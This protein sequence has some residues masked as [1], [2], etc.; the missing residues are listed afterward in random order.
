MAGLRSLRNLAAHSATDEIG[1]DRAHDYLALADAV[2]YALRVKRGKVPTAAAD[3][4]D[5]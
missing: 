3:R 1:A 4:T 5:D 2:M